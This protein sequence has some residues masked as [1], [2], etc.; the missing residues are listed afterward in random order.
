MAGLVQGG[1][2]RVSKASATPPRVGGSSPSLPSSR[3]D[4]RAYCGGLNA[5]EVS[6]TKLR[7]G[8]YT[9]INASEA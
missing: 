3:C 6:N 2:P 1:A 4:R 7:V 9:Y 8:S 5:L